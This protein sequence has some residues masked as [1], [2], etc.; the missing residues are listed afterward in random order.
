VYVVDPVAAQVRA[1]SGFA[2]ARLH[3]SRI[4]QKVVRGESVR[5]L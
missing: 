5:D 3:Q 1:A 2:P 4:R